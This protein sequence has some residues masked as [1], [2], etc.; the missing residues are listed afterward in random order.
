MV[1]MFHWWSIIYFILK[2][3]KFEMKG[4]RAKSNCSI[5]MKGRF[6]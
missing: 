2:N 6:E 1:E 3:I 4:H 5:N